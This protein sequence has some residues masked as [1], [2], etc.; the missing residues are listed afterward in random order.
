MPGN[1]IVLSNFK[2][3]NFESPSAPEFPVKQN[4]VAKI[5]VDPKAIEVKQRH[6]QPMWFLNMFQREF[7]Q[8]KIRRQVKIYQGRSWNEISNRW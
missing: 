3:F 5:Q 2:L 1:F 8:L 4:E 7:R 6:H